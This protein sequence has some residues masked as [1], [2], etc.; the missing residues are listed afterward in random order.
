MRKW[1]QTIPD[2][3]EIYS[4]FFDRWYDE[5][6]RQQKGFTHTR[7]DLFNPYRPGLDVAQITRLTAESQ[8]EARRRVHVMLGTARSD[9]QTYL[10][11]SGDIDEKWVQVFDDYYS[12]KKIAEVIKRSD[13]ED[14]SN[15]LIVL[16]CQFG[17]VL[18]HVLLQHQPRLC[19][20]PEWPYWESSLYD[21]VSGN[22]IPTFHWAMKKFSSYGV[23][24]GFVP[25]IKMCIH[26][27]DQASKKEGGCGNEGSP[28]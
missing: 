22:V 10:S 14:F 8:A 15:D 13:P 16:V 25:K 19:W 2:D 11:V 17:A 28:A 27:L 1:R 18:G 12:T 23:D 26:I 4:R 7:P 21:P 20:L 6:D 3:N 9:W 24:D 5:E